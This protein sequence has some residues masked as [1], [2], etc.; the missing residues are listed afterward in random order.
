[1]FFSFPVGLGPFD[2]RKGP[3]QHQWQAVASAA[4]LLIEKNA[5]VSVT[6][7]PIKG[8]QRKAQASNW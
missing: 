8:R 3:K 2:H 5:P 6:V 1:V 7:N 4:F